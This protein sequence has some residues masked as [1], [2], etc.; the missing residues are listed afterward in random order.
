L[1]DVDWA[2]T[3]DWMVDTGFMQPTDDVDDPAVVA[4]AVSRAIGVWS[5]A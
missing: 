1:V 5:R 4:D 3:V 2:A